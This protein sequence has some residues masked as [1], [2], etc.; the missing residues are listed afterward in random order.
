VQNATR[1]GGS[2]ASYS[3]K[4]EFK[5]RPGYYLFWLWFLLSFGKPWTILLAV[6]GKT[7]QPDPTPLSTMLLFTYCEAYIYPLLGNDPVN[8]FYCWTRLVNNRGYPLLGNGSVFLCGP[9]RRLIGDKEGRL[10]SV[11]EREAERR[12]TWAVKEVEFGWRLTVSYC[13]WLWLR[14]IVQEDANKSNRPLKN[15]LL[16]VTEP[17]TRDVYFLT[18]VVSLLGISCFLIFV[19]AV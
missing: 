3:D 7:V 19:I 16:F 13:N 4:L 1:T 12:D 5:S 10:Q 18:A 17:R 15:P 2:P 14:E 6:D 8:N 9:C 11:V